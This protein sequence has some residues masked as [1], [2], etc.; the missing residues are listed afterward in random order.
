[1]MNT[2]R[3]S[4]TDF[5]RIQDLVQAT[6]QRGARLTVAFECPATAKGASTTVDIVEANDNAIATKARSRV[7]SAAIQS[8][9]KSVTR[10]LRG[11]FGNNVFGK[12]ANEVVSDRAKAAKATGGFTDAEVETAIVAAFGNVQDQ[13]V[14]QSAGERYVHKSAAAAK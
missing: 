14:W 13:F 3:S 8:V 9:Q 12:L 7:R 2:P 5:S 1:M 6:E 11:L 4:E 10:T